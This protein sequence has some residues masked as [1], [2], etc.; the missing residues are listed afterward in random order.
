MNERFNYGS[1][2]SVMVEFA[3]VLILLVMLVFGISEIGRAIYQ[4]NTLTKSIEAGARYMSRAVDILEFDPA[5]ITP[6]EQCRISSGNWDA[7][8]LRAKNIILYGV[9]SAGATARLPNMEVTKIDVEPYIEHSLASGGA[10]VIKVAAKAKFVSIFSN[11]APLPPMYGEESSQTGGL[12]LTAT[13]EE[14]YI[15]E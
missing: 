8:V 4:Q 14:R 6:G 2:G 13:T 1:A 11:D 3:G 7:A 12:L 15:G 5:G 10:C 9:E